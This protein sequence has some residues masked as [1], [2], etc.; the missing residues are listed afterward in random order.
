MSL[1]LQ[2]AA[3]PSAPMSLVPSRG[4]RMPGRALR[5]QVWIAR[6]ASLWGFAGAV[7]VQTAVFCLVARLALQL[8]SAALPGLAAS[9][10]GLGIGALA[11]MGSK[12]L[13]APPQ[14]A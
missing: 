14:L 13:T 9:V 8:D 1:Y 4:R 3:E 7:L 2:I 5:S 10:V 12:S 11:M 6:L